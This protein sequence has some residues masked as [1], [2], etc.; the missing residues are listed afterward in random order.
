[1]GLLKYP[2]NVSRAKNIRPFRFTAG[3]VMMNEPQ[4]F[5]GLILA[6]GKS[7]RMGKDKSVMVYHD[8]PQLQVAY[9]LLELY[10]SKVYISSRQDQIFS[11]PCDLYS[12]INDAEPFEN[13]GPIGGILSAMKKFPSVSW[14]VLAC[15]LPFISSQTIL[16][17]LNHR[18]PGNIA[19]AYRN[20]FDHLPEPLC[21]IW[22]KGYFSVI[23]SYFL[24]GIHC[25]RKVLIHSK[26]R[27]ID[28]QAIHEL[29]NVNNPD[30]AI[31]ALQHLNQAKKENK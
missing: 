14:I 3:G 18:D 15:D 9:E 24:K 31:K 26:A 25:P 5:F 8:K 1:M 12:R 19:T 20:R 17:L 6:G 29:D 21:A 23:E 28:L 11:P 16:N 13:K 4:N 22:E 2:V 10:C 27:L 30:E 7:S